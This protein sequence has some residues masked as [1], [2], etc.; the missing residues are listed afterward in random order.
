MSTGKIVAIVLG[1]AVL[2]VL[3]LAGLGAWLWQ[4]Y[5]P[6]LREA[7]QEV[8]AEAA[9]F[10]A[11]TDNDG[12]L[13][14]AL[15]RYERC[16]GGFTCG[17]TRNIFLTGCLRASTPAPGFC[18]EVPPSDAF[19]ASVTWRLQRCEEMGLTDPQCGNLFGQIQ[20]FCDS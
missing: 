20:E 17:V 2:I 18:D 11:T 1:S 3:M 12:C 19:S 16:G 10:G 8:V 15:D 7:G 9:E 13:A 4:T 6:Q 14:E 5:A